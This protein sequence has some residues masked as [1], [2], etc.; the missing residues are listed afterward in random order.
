VDVVTARCA[1][2]IFSLG[3]ENRGDALRGAIGAKLIECDI[4]FGD[5]MANYDGGRTHSGD[6]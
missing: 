4:F 2:F 3:T 1:D 6:S 5:A